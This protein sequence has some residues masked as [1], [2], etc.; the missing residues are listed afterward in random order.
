MRYTA[1]FYLT[2]EGHDI[3]QVGVTP[4]VELNNADEGDSQRDYAVEYAASMIVAE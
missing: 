3:D 1:A 2:P 4:N